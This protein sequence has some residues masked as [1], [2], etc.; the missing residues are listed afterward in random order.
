MKGGPRLCSRMISSAHYTKVCLK[1]GA[2]EI[3]HN[4]GCG[5]KWS[6]CTRK[7]T[8]SPPTTLGQS[9]PPIVSTGVSF[10]CVREGKGGGVWGG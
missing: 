1:F 8:L 9:P 7:V 5:P 4:I 2:Q 6:S 3:S 10:H